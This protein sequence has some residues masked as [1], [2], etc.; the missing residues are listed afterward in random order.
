[1]RRQTSRWL[2]LLGLLLFLLMATTIWVG[3]ASPMQSASDGQA[4]FKAKCTACHTIGGGKLIGPDLKG[5]TQRREASWLSA[6]I[7]APDK[8][9]ASGDATAKQLVAQFGMQMPNLGLS[10][11]DVASLVA[12][13]QSADGGAPAPSAPAQA[14]QA[15]AQPAPEL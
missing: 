6:W 3:A 11:A 4:V 9:V 1:M 2:I 13:F 8:V 5:V 10:D 12:Y 15:Q 7:K 14:T